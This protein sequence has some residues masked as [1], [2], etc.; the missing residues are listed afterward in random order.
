MTSEQKRE[1]WKQHFTA[2]QESKLSQKDYCQQYNLS[3]S[4]FGYWRKQLSAPTRHEG[5]FIPVPVSS[6]STD[7]ITLTIANLRMDV[8]AT[9]FD[10]ILPIVLRNL[11]EVT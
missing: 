10:L 7:P 1:H 2:W 3:F 11:R 6:T 8:P 9:L 4:T 5:K